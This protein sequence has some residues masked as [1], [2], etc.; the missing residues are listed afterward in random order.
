M[1]TM[2]IDGVKVLK[3]EEAHPEES[4]RTQ[5]AIG[6]LHLWTLITGEDDLRDT[7]VGNRQLR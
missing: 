4:R 2:M 3:L 6:M 5:E 7:T 1:K